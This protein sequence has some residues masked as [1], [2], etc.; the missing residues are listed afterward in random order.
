M[1]PP[2]TPI[3]GIS[4]DWNAIGKSMRAPNAPAEAA[5]DPNIKPE[6]VAAVQ[7]CEDEGGSVR[8]LKTQPTKPPARRR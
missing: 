3:P 7:E 2:F 5:N 8:H 1:K 4:A 6:P